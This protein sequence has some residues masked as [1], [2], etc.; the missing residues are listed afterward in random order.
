[1]GGGG[2]RDRKGERNVKNPCHDV[3]SRIGHFTRD[4]IEKYFS[5]RGRKTFFKGRKEVSGFLE[6][7]IP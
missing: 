7:K 6:R 2:T 5:I 1:M 3:C 4:V